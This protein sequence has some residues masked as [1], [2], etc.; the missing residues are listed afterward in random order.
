MNG[1]GEQAEARPDES[2]GAEAVTL[3]WS[4]QGEREFK[5]LFASATI[6]L[7]LALSAVGF[8]NAIR[9]EAGAQLA[10][11]LFALVLATVAVLSWYGPFGSVGARV[12]VDHRGLWIRHQGWT[13]WPTGTRIEL[14]VPRHLPASE[15]GI[16]EAV[17]EDGRRK[18]WSKSMALRYRG[19]RLGWT[20]TTI[21]KESTDAVLIEQRNPDLKRPWWLIKCRQH[22][23]L[24]R[25][26]EM[27]RT[28]G[29]EAGEPL[30]PSIG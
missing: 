13:L 20:R 4:E 15:I 12:S 16:V 27:A 18:M 6:A 10:S 7:L 28:S 9:G 29:G 5:D 22:D 1:D 26:L 11:A 3:P 8:W 30:P 24:V 21:D 2:P 17:S 23:E 14:L 25:A 19:K